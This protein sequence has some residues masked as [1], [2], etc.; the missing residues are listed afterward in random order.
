MNG[1]MADPSVSTTKAPKSAMVSSTGSSQN[2]FRIERKAQN[3]FK[4]TSMPYSRQIKTTKQERE[5][6]YLPRRTHRSI[7]CGSAWG[8]H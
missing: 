4:N 3:S 2:F 7:G 1:A 8:T 5:L 6:G